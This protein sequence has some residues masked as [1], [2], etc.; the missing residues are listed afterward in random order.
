MRPDHKLELKKAHCN[1]RSELMYLEQST[2]DWIQRNRMQK[3]YSA[4]HF[5]GHNN[6]LLIQISY[7]MNMEL[8]KI[9]FLFQRLLQHTQ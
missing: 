3:M 4:I 2:C 1:A 8:T 6:I 7:W 9:A 5:N